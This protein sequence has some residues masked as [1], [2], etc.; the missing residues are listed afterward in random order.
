[1]FASRVFRFFKRSVGISETI[2]YADF[3]DRVADFLEAREWTQEQE[4]RDKNGYSVDIQSRRAVQFCSWGAIYRNYLDLKPYIGSES[5]YM[6]QREFSKYLMTTEYGST[7][8]RLSRLTK[9]SWRKPIIINWNDGVRF[10]DKESVVQTFRNFAEE[11]R[12]L[13]EQQYLSR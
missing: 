6:W 1:M 4:A 5:L 9:D 11:Q 2:S 3:G 8:E 10:L 13:V 7:I 12:S